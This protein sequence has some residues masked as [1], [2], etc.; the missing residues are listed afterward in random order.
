MKLEIQEA[1]NWIDGNLQD[2]ITL[3]KISDYIGYSEFHTS[4]KFKEYTGSTLRRYITLRRL[5]SAAKD[6]R[7]KNIRIIDVAMNYGFSSQESFTKSFKQAF[8]LNPGEETQHK[9]WPFSTSITITEP[10][11]GLTILLAWLV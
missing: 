2:E 3:K 10:E 1:I 6:L 7:D 4:R 9:S 5:S 11:C 8:G